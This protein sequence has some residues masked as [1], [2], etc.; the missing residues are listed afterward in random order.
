MPS[1]AKQV[2]PFASC[3]ARRMPVLFGMPRD[4]RRLLHLRWHLPCT[5]AGL[6]TASARSRVRVHRDRELDRLRCSFAHPCANP[7]GSAHRPVFVTAI[8]LMVALQFFSMRL[9][10]SATCPT[11]ATTRWLALHDVR[12]AADVHLLRRL[13]PDGRRHLHSD[14]GPSAS[15][16]SGSC[17]PAAPRA[18]VDL[19]SSRESAYQ[20]GPNPSS[21][22]TT[23][24]VPPWAPR[25]TDPASTNSSALAEVRSKIEAARRSDP[26]SM[27]TERGIT[28]CRNSPSRSGRPCRQAVDARP[29]PR[30]RKRL[31]KQ[32]LPPSASQSR[33]ANAAPSA[34]R[35][36]LDNPCPGHEGQHRAVL[37]AEEIERHHALSADRRRSRQRR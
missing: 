18:Y 19:L 5:E 9:S 35:P 12:D 28:V 26:A 10:S 32:G 22:T 31:A 6:L 8:V 13:L 34:G 29:D 23:V 4:H 33:S 15:G 3:C 24:S 37:S 30:R 1:S 7:R 11:W 25:P 36:G 2:S 20:N 17:R 16:P 21:R 27:T 14:N